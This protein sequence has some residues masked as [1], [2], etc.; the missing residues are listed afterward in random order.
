M[1]KPTGFVFYRGASLIDGAPIVGIAVLRSSNVKTGD[2]VQTFI[3]RADVA[4]LDA[5]KSGADV[6]ICGD[7]QHRG[8]A[9]TGNPDDRRTCYVDVA[10]SVSS[11]FGAFSRG[12]Y[13][14]V[15]L[16]D[17]A[18]MLSG[19]DVRMGAYGDPAAIPA[20]VW[21]QLAQFASGRT[22]YTH[23]WR[24]SFAQEMRDL[25]MASADSEWDR[26]TARAIGW[27]TFRVRSENES[28][29]FAEIACPASPEGGDRRQCKTCLACDGADRAGKASVAII[30]HGK[31]AR[32]FATA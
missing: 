28:L 6:S 5:I 27:R 29:G 31:M 3:L 22:G 15:S 32:H 11:V 25:V 20:H 30:V 17:A 19:R 12:S 16:S 13:P 2:M 23:Q 8:A 26:D 14:D 7:C 10:K 18:L 9:A 4:P 1:K 21:R 24:E